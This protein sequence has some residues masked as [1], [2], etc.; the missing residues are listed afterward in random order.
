MHQR[1]VHTLRQLAETFPSPVLPAITERVLGD[2]FYDYLQTQEQ[3]RL[4]VTWR[5]RYPNYA[6]LDIHSKADP[7]ESTQASFSKVRYKNPH[8]TEHE[9]VLIV[10]QALRD[11]IDRILPNEQAL[12]QVYTKPNHPKNAMAFMRAS[13]AAWPAADSSAREQFVDVGLVRVMLQMNLLQ[14][15]SE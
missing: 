13:N 6:L 11:T 15:Y 3:D 1:R 2:T 14:N 4:V 10:V 9:A 12:H 7:R 8:L 5:Q